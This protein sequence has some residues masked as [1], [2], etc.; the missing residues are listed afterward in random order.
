MILLKENVKYIATFDEAIPIKTNN[1]GIGKVL[2]ILVCV[3]IGILLVGSVISGNNLFLELGPMGLIILVCLVIGM[4]IGGKTQFKAAPM[5]IWFFDDYL[6]MLKVKHY[7]SKKLSRK[8]YDK[9]YYKDIRG[10]K[11]N[12]VTQQITFQGLF[13][14]EWYKYNKDGSIESVASYNKTVDTI[15]CFYF[16]LC[17]DIDFLSIFKEY[18]PYNIDLKFKR[19]K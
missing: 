5:E 10:I 16:N 6:V 4:H 2:K 12:E 1:K 7:Y 15:R 19:S 11:W 14:L 17:Q 13:E 3:V 18:V 9:I 8:E